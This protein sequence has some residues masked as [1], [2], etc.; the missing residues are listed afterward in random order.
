MRSVLSGEKGLSIAALFQ[1]FP[2]WLI[3]EAMP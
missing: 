3:E 1:T 2:D